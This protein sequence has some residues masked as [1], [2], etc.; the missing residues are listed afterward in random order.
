MCFFIQRTNAL[1]KLPFLILSLGLHH[2]SNMELD[3]QSLFGLLCR[4][5]LIETRNSPL[6]PHLGSYTRA[7]LVSQDRRHLF[8][9]SGLYTHHFLVV[10]VYDFVYLFDV[11][12]GFGPVRTHKQC[13]KCEGCV[14]FKCIPVVLDTE[15]TVHRVAMAT[16]WRT[17]HHEGKNHPSYQ[18]PALPVSQLTEA[19]SARVLVWVCTC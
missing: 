5:V 3:L 10:S 18:Y 11:F 6:S 9:P 1:K 19:G 14:V 15:Y 7:L 2:R 13:C 12:R 16:F 4:A 17:F 8:K